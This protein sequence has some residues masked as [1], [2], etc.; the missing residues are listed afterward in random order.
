MTVTVVLERVSKWYG[1]RRSGVVL[2]DVDLTLQPGELT[3]VT[4]PNGSGK[5]TLLRILA[6]ASTPSRGRVRGRPRNTGYLPDRFPPRLRF[7]PNEYL[8]HMGAIRGLPGR[9][10]AEVTGELAGRLEYR[11][12]LGTRMAE[13]SKGTCQ[14]VAL[15]QALLGEPDLLVLDEPWSGLDEAAQREL[16]GLLRQ[17]CQRGGCVVVSDHRAAM[18]DK[19]ADRV[20]AITDGRLVARDGAEPAVLVEL[21]RPDGTVQRQQVPRHQVDKLLVQSLHDGLSVRRVQP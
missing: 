19:L 2:R 20:C 12:F 6:G 18:L 10:V 13:L 4:G 1:L 8:R 15:T 17:A 16:T 7:T 14:K 11:Q 9:L 3:A 21:V 5:S